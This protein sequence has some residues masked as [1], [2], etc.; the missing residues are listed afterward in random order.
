MDIN[1]FYNHR[2]RC[3]ICNKLLLNIAEFD[4]AIYQDLSNEFLL[5]GSL[6]YEYDGSRFHKFS[7]E[8]YKEYQ[9]NSTYHSQKRKAMG[10]ISKLSINS[11]AINKR[12]FPKLNISNYLNYDGLKDLSAE[13]AILDM[14][15]QSSC[16]SKQH[17]YYYQT[18]TILPGANIEHDVIHLDSEMLGIF[19]YR[20]FNAIDAKTPSTLITKIT[21]TAKTSEQYSLPF[22]PIDSW[23]LTNK[24]SFANQ[25]QSYNLLK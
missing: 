5:I 1:Q 24:Q 22:I 16:V 8:V 6:L 9:N 7:Y 11:F 21:N 19:G 14:R 17:I 23:K 2:H 10:K 25:V 20:I 15:L 3:P 4:I 13:F 18:A 12:V